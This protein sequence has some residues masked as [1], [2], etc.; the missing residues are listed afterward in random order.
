MS[1]QK[2]SIFIAISVEDGLD[3]AGPKMTS[4]SSGSN[5]I[6]T[7]REVINWSEFFN[8][9]QWRYVS[10]LARSQYQWSWIGVIANR[11]PYALWCTTICNL[12]WTTDKN[13]K[14]NRFQATLGNW[15]KYFLTKTIWTGTAT[16]LYTFFVRIRITQ[17]FV[18]RHVVALHRWR[19]QGSNIHQFLNLIFAMTRIWR[20][21]LWMIDSSE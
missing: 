17:L 6:S 11:S 9:S 14:Q 20:S 18:Y 8:C 10:T 5:W 2:E 19:Q 1:S 4:F 21:W 15:W 16:F 3:L 12:I 13:V 7:I